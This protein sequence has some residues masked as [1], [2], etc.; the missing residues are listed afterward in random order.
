MR[1][2]NGAAVVRSG[3]PRLLERSELAN[4]GGGRDVHG[5][6]TAGIVVD[7]LRL[8]L[9]MMKMMGVIP[10]EEL[11]V[12]VVPC[13]TAGDEIDAEVLRIMSVVGSGSSGGDEA[14]PGDSEILIFGELGFGAAEV[15]LELAELMLEEGDD[16]NAAVD[17]VTEAH[18]GLVGQGIDSILAL[19][20][21]QLVQKLGDVACS[22]HFVDVC[23]FLGLVRRE[24]GGKHALKL[25]L[26]PKEL[27]CRTRRVRRRRCHLC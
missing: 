16:A 12:V 5:Q 14:L 22:E 21:E 4:A 8:R 27:T 11:V 3:S 24:V 9:M 7:H 18:V 26:A 15:D 17:G 6:K 13:C 2:I 25:A 19:A 20:G 1:G 10:G 23:K